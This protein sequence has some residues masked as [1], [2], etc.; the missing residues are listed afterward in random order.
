MQT[1]KFKNS[2]Q[3]KTRTWAVNVSNQTNKKDEE[4]KKHVHARQLSG[5]I[6]KWINCG[7][8]FPWQLVY[9]WGVLKRPSIRQ[10]TIAGV[11]SNGQAICM[12]AVQWV[13]LQKVSLGNNASAVSRILS[14]LLR[15]DNLINP[16][17]M[18]LRGELRTLSSEKTN[19]Q[20]K[21][22]VLPTRFWTYSHQQN[23]LQIAWNGPRIFE[24]KSVVVALLGGNQLDADLDDNNHLATPPCPKWCVEHSIIQL[25]IIVISNK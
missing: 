12:Q 20:A 13:T 11:H 18:K 22:E 15:A 9:N 4:V 25:R 17:G 24:D 23:A 8:Y 5:H 3:Q 7:L 16:R 14:A 2:Q 19:K 10:I 21:L 1:R 6:F